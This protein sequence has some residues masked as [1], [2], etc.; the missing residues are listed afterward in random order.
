[1]L[2]ILFIFSL[3]SLP[4]A[5]TGIK[6]Y[7]TPN[8]T[9]LEEVEVWTAAANQIFFSLGPTFGGLIT[10]ASYNK[11]NNNCHRDALLV[12]FINCGT[13]VFAGFVIFSILG[14]MAELNN[15][16][17]KDIVKS[18]PAL[19]FVAYPEAISNMPVP[20]LWS[21]LFFCMLLS[22]MVQY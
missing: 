15:V 14:F 11:F 12:S 8:F 5:G 16:E 13:S 3:S 4:G 1:M 18:G 20:P 6:F 10:L 9:K 2:I 7:I 17:V 19:A 21:F 22:L